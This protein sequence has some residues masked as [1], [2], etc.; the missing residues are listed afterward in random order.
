MTANLP[1][2]EGR[3]RFDAV[4]QITLTETPGT[5]HVITIAS[6]NTDYYLCSTTNLLTAI[7][8]AINATGSIAN[9][10]L[11]SISD[12]SDTAA[13]GKVT[14]ARTAGASTFALTWETTAVRDALGFVGSISA[15]STTATGDYHA[16]YLFLPNVKRGPGLAPDGDDGLPMTDA[17][18]TVAPSGNSYSLSYSTRYI[19]KLSWNFLTG[20]KALIY[21]A[22][23]NAAYERFYLDVIGAG[24]PLRYYPARDTDGTYV[25]YQVI[26]P[27]RFECTPHIEAWRHSTKSLWNS[28]YDVIKYAN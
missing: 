22:A 16:R 18:V 5:A 28:S 15:G 9:T 24:N 12:D 10:Y 1:K 20:D 11:L 4:Q 25:T 17:L 26:N 3:I 14:I 27:A 6:A 8:S 19:D 23:T 13:T 21:L 7:T 2:L